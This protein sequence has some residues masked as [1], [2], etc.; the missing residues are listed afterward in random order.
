MAARPLLMPLAVS[1]R[2][3]RPH[4]SAPLRLLNISDEIVSRTRSYESDAARIRDRVA[5]RCSEG[6]KLPKKP[7]RLQ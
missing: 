1:S 6:E 3:I 7:W 5:A 4:C 2:S